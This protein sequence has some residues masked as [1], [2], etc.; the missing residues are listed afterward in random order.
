M[1]RNRKYRTRLSRIV[2]GETGRRVRFEILP[3]VYNPER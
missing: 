3:G 1:S 2:P